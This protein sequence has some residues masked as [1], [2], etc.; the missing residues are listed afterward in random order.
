[1]EA[2]KRTRALLAIGATA[3]M[4]AAG[5]AGV[6]SSSHAEAHLAGDYGSCGHGGTWCFDQR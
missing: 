2:V 3:L 6:S 5:A 1:M 4:L